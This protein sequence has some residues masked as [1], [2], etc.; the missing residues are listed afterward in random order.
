[1]GA[2]RYA[3]SG[4]VRRN[5]ARIDPHD[6]ERKRLILPSRSELRA[7][8]DDDARAALRGEP[9]SDGAQPQLATARRSLDGSDADARALDSI[10][11][12]LGCALVVEISSR[13]ANT[14]NGLG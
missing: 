2:R 14:S 12:R 13:P 3:F 4:Q 5:A 10:G 6:P 11:D 1:M 7:V 9:G 8:A